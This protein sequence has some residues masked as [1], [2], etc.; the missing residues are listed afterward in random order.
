MAEQILYEGKLSNIPYTPAPLL[1]YEGL[2]LKLP[3]DMKKA[4]K[5]IEA[6]GRWDTTTLSEKD[7]EQSAT[8]KSP[9]SIN[10]ESHRW[11]P[12]DERE[13]EALSVGSAPKSVKSRKSVKS[14]ARSPKSTSSVEAGGSG[15]NT[16]DDRKDVKS[17]IDVKAE[18]KE[19]RKEDKWAVGANRTNVEAEGSKSNGVGIIREN[20]GQPN[21]ASSGTSSKGSEK[22][23]RW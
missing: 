6:T 12:I 21:S 11:N 19:G 23:R 7:F 5:R 14:L 16:L 2:W 1:E 15:F 3:Q 4:V 22:V 10:T 13:P 18:G 9:R 8:G 20:A 17:V